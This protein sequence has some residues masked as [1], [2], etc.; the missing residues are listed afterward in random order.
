MVVLVMMRSKD[1]TMSTLLLGMEALLVVVD[2]A[3]LAQV[4]TRV[5]SN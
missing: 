5:E 2:V 1:W 4:G 3:A